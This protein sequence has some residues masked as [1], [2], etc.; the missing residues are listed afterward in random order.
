VRASLTFS[1]NPALGRALDV[2]LAF[3]L[4][5]RLVIRLFFLPLVMDEQRFVEGVQELGQLMARGDH[6]VTIL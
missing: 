6:D 1:L 5:R 2:V 4:F 3:E